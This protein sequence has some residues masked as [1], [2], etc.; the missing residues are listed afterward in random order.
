LGRSQA[1][2][3]A[4]H[5]RIVDAAAAQVRRDG[6]DA[7]R[8]SDLMREAGLTHGGFYRHFGSREELI[9]AA[10]DQALADGS[11]QTEAGEAADPQALAKVIDG[12]VS[13]AH[14]DNPGMGCGVAALPADV[15]RSG[16]RARGAYARQV[17]RYIERLVG[18]IRRPEADAKRDEAVMMLSAL[19]GALS[20]ARAVEDP[21]LSDE[22]LA[23]TA[24]ALHRRIDEHAAGA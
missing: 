24:R 18:L 3:D 4:S 9:D 10:I 14:R 23:G 21:E 22:I 2:K 5:K 17:R 6:V 13:K 1:E 8:V 12:Y 11:R 20:M 7:V 15:S 16:S 19:V